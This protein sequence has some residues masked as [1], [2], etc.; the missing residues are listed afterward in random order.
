MPGTQSIGE[1]LLVMM[2]VNISDVSPQE[3]DLIQPGRLLLLHNSVKK[4]RISFCSIFE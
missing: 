2:E 4:D 3:Y 1:I